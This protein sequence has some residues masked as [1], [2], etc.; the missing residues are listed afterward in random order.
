MVIVLELRKL[1]A[2]ELAVEGVLGHFNEGWATM[3]AGEWIF[4]GEQLF[5][6]KISLSAI[7][8]VPGNDGSLAGAAG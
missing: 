6:L 2:K 8:F 5:A 3:G 4:A 1:R 7:E